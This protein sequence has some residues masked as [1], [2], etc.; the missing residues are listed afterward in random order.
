[1]CRY[2]Y[3]KYSLGSTKKHLQVSA[4]QNPY[5]RYEFAERRIVGG[6]DAGVQEFP[7][8]VAIALDDLFFCGG[9]LISENFVL[10]AAHCLLTYGDTNYKE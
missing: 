1:M 10:T 9:A 5:S 2:L 7:W 4:E 8:Q 3:V 6:T